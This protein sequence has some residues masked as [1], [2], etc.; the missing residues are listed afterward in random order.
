M[1]SAGHQHKHGSRTYESDWLLTLIN[2][3]REGYITSVH[4]ISLI[5]RLCFNCQ[6]ASSITIS[7]ATG[8]PLLGDPYLMLIDRITDPFCL[9][10]LLEARCGIVMKWNMARDAGCSDDRTGVEV[11][12]EAQPVVAVVE[13][14]HV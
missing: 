13:T 1:N 14:V 7:A 9:C 12:V 8:A 3:L 10:R 5:H 11:S 2:A 4:N 6:E